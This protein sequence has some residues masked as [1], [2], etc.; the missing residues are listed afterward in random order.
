MQISYTQLISL[1]D[2]LLLAKEY[3]DRYAGTERNTLLE[4]QNVIQQ[5]LEQDE[6]K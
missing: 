4:A 1:I 6:K 2:G 3:V 5:L